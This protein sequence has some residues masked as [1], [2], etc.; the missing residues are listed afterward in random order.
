MILKRN[1]LRFFAQLIVQNLNNC[2]PLFVT[3]LFMTFL[4]LPVPARPLLDRAA[5]AIDGYYS[6]CERLLSGLP[7][8]KQKTPTDIQLPSEPLW[9]DARNLPQVALPKLEQVPLASLPPGLVESMQTDIFKIVGAYKG[10]H[11]GYR[12]V[13]ETKSIWQDMRKNFDPEHEHAGDLTFDLRLYPHL[14]GPRAAF[15]FGYQ[16]LDEN[17]LTVPTPEELIGGLD[18]YNEGLSP[19]DPARIKLNYFVSH[20]LFE[21]EDSYIDHFAIE[22]KKVF[23]KVGR[24]FFHDVSAHA[25]E[26]FL[27]PTA[28]IEHTHN[29]VDIGSRFL[30]EYGPELSAETVQSIKHLLSHEIDN[31]ANAIFRF[32]PNK[33]KRYFHLVGQRIKDLKYAAIPKPTNDQQIE[34]RNQIES[35]AWQIDPYKDDATEYYLNPKSSLFFFDVEQF[36]KNAVQNAPDHD[37]HLLQTFLVFDRLQNHSDYNSFDSTLAKDFSDLNAVMA[38]IDETT[39]TNS[40]P[41]LAQHP[42]SRDFVIRFYRLQSIMNGMGI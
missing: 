3:V 16:I 18:R 4:S 35:S 42:Y 22:Y 25:M 23:S 15:Y 36:F 7:A 14:L 37:R 34:S 12:L 32:F 40:L 11:G 5:E 9:P 31:H 26:G 13:I 17:Y 1:P 30:R 29:V 33:L 19:N 24:N 38:A 41:L 21:P 39:L 28:A 20:S 10:L 6:W 8:A 2:Q 27:N